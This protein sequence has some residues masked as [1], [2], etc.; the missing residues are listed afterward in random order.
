V[1]VYFDASVLVALFVDDVFTERARTFLDEH[2]PTAIVSDFASAEFASSISRLVRMGVMRADAAPAA[3]R[4]FDSWC[5]ESTSELLLI[6]ADVAAATAILRRRDS[7]LRTPD[8][9]H[10]VMARRAGAALAT[11][12]DRLRDSAVRFGVEGAPA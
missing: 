11:F 12:D 3:F 2:A 6:S 9:L 4:A 10:L 5:A 8:A 7:P 1:S